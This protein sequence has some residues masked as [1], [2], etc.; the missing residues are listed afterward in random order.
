MR[1]SPRFL[2]IHQSFQCQRNQRIRDRPKTHNHQRSMLMVIFFYVSIRVCVCV[3]TFISSI[4][5]VERFW[6][7]SSWPMI[8]Q[9][10]LNREFNCRSN[11]SDEKHRFH[12]VCQKSKARKINW[13]LVSIGSNHLLQ[14]DEKKSRWLSLFR[15]LCVCAYL[16]SFNPYVTTFSN[17]QIFFTWVNGRRVYNRQSLPMYVRALK[18]SIHWTNAD[19]KEWIQ[20]RETDTH[21]LP[22]YASGSFRN[23]SI[24][25]SSFRL[26]DYSASTNDSV[27]V[28]LIDQN[29]KS[30][31]SRSIAWCA[32][33]R[34]L[35]KKQIAFVYHC[36]SDVDLGILPALSKTIVQE[37]D[38]RIVS[39]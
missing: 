22:P 29:L 27:N 1:F 21:L 5:L 8:C 12:S 3:S 26:I 6:S 36:V 4:I 19:Q 33:H 30:S 10:W 15:C 13:S 2:I 25:C 38:V 23:V 11:R 9:V 7:F 31:L 14:F 16:S 18:Y 34:S 32:F 20:E 24:A 35:Q 28:P 39:I 17:T 37:M